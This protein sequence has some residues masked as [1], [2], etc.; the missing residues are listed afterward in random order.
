VFGAEFWKEDSVVVVFLE[1]S[2]LPLR[3]IMLV[4][5]CEEENEQEEHDEESR[6]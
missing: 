4:Y 1:T 3:T 5:S 6:W 2:F